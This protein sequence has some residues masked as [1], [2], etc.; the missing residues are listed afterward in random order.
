MPQTQVFPDRLRDHSHPLIPEE[1]VEVVLQQAT[2]HEKQPEI[3]ILSEEECEALE[4][5]QARLEAERKITPEWER[6]AK[7]AA[8]IR[9]L[10]EEECEALEWKASQELT[11][12]PRTLTPEEVAQYKQR[13]LKRRFQPKTQQSKKN[14]HLRKNIFLLTHKYLWVLWANGDVFLCEH[15]S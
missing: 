15:A 8:T 12:Q 5:A 7:E 11:C 1:R 9:I 2:H 3:R 4:Q 13:A 10:S 14:T 6:M